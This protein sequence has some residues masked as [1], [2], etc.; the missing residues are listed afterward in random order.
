MINAKQGLIERFLAQ[1]TMAA[2]RDTPVVL[3]I[4]PRQCGKTTLVR[5][6]ITGKRDYLTLDDA[7]TRQAALSDPT[8]FVRDLDHAI[9]DEVQHAPDVL[10]AIKQSVDE[11]RRPGRFLLTGSANIL[12]LPR[13]PDSLA[14]RIEIITLLP[15]SQAEIFG[16]RPAFLQKAFAGQLAKPIHNITGKALVRT[17]L[18]GGYPEMLQRT[19]APR[20]AA[21]VNSYVKAT[22]QR[23]VREV[24]SIEKL[25]HMPALLRALAH[26][27]GQL[28][29]F[30]SIGGQIRID[31]KTTRNYTRVFEELFL[32]RR[33]EPWHNNRLSRLIKTPKL[34]FLDS[35]LLSNLLK[36]NATKIAADR[37]LFG[38]VLETF[39]F[40]EILKQ[41]SWLDFRCDLSHYRDKE[42][43]EVDLVLEN[44]EG[45]MIGVE[46]KASASVKTTDFNGLRKLS[47]ASKNFKLGLVLYDGERALPFGDRMYAAPISC[48]WGT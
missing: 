15:L 16:R 29:N 38:P 35:G 12:S 25:E 3:I 40:S 4:G 6:L 14:G 41:E 13:T 30:T 47:S 42:K 48:L 23:D 5:Q 18:Q 33:I 2:L 21:W 22:V 24:S 43:N 46:V 39:V 1:N 19:S 28:T 32:L 27:S 36:L 11:D 17:V 34:H 37:S 45:H 7:A 8:G 20:Q 31:D 10:L 44:A 26:H 9:I